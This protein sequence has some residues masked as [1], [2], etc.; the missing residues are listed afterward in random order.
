MTSPLFSNTPPLVIWFSPFLP[1]IPV[2]FP[3]LHLP[4]SFFPFCSD[5]FFL[6]LLL[7]S[8]VP[9]GR[10]ACV[11]WGWI[12]PHVALG[13]DGQQRTQGHLPYYNPLLTRP[14]VRSRLEKIWKGTHEEEK[15]S[16]SCTSS[17]NIWL[18]FAQAAPP[19]TWRERIS[20][21][22]ST[23]WRWTASLWCSVMDGWASSRHWATLSQQM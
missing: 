20:A 1:T 23:V 9:P 18:V 15:K 8:A 6:L 2:C 10:P 22:W 17:I 12:P 16:F 13:W 19:W 4:P 21:V 5:P 7:Q 11:H 3:L 14:S